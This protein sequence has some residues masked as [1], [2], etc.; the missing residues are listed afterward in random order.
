M[1]L[2]AEQI[3]EIIKKY[4]KKLDGVSFM[5]IENGK[6][7][8]FDAADVNDLHKKVKAWAE[9][10]VDE[11]DPEFFFEFYGP[12]LYVVSSAQDGAYEGARRVMG[13][14]EVIDVL[15][16]MNE[17]RKEEILDYVDCLEEEYLQSLSRDRRERI[18]SVSDSPT[19]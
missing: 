8:V 11:D 19:A 1:N 3:R 4:D 9:G 16:C 12:G 7:T 15:I 18:S 14:P 6:I 10:N 17:D 13:V 5:F 2:S